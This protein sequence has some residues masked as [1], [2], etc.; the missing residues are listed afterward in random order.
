MVLPAPE[1]FSGPEPRKYLEDA[2]S[3]FDRSCG[4][5]EEREETG[6]SPE[7]IGLD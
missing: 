1:P 5:F 6:A 7:T 2:L 4:D 3:A